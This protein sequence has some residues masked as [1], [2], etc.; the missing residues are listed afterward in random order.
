MGC[1]QTVSRDVSP[2]EKQTAQKIDETKIEEIRG[3]VRE[4][5]QQ[6]DSV[7]KDEN[8][9]RII[10]D[11]GTPPFAFRDGMKHIGFEIDLGEA[12]A[13]EMNKKA[14]WI[15][16]NFNVTTYASALDMGKADIA[17]ASITIN[18]DRQRLVAFSR[19]Y[20]R[21]DLAVATERD[22]D[23][24]HVDFLTGLKG[25]TVG[26]MRNTTA[27][28]YVRDNFRSVVRKKYYTPERVVQALRDE[29]VYC[30][31]MDEAIL[32]WVLAKQGYRFKI[33]ERHLNHE[34][35]GIATSK[36]NIQL[37]A[38]INTALDRLD[39]NGVYNMIYEQWFARRKDIEIDTQ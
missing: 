31:F 20:Y 2:A 12:I 39:K 9:L 8:V 27:E 11:P 23:W 5:K 4:E 22:V 26:V 14:K 10:T 35:Y 33:V 17:L 25:H 29:R 38:E 7:K 36:N 19:P 16:M 1:A 28:T 6:E 3:I 15:P 21:T 24:E 30:I 37:L 18:Q 34:D 13:R 32:R